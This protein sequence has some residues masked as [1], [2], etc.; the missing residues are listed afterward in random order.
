MGCGSSNT[1]NPLQKIKPR[2]IHCLIK[3]RFLRQNTPHPKL[4]TTP[5]IRQESFPSSKDPGPAQSSSQKIAR[6]KLSQYIKNSHSLNGSRSKSNGGMLRE[7]P[8][9]PINGADEY[10]ANFQ[11]IGKK[12]FSKSGTMSVHPRIFGMNTDSIHHQRRNCNQMSNPTPISG[13]HLEKILQGDESTSLL[14]EED[15]DLHDTCEL[16]S[17]QVASSRNC[18][19]IASIEKLSDMNDSYDYNGSNGKTPVDSSCENICKIS[20]HPYPSS[21]KKMSIVE[22]KKFDEYFQTRQKKDSNLI[23]DQAENTGLLSKSKSR[24]SFKVSK[25]SSA[26]QGKYRSPSEKRNPE[27]SISKAKFVHEPM[28]IDEN[29]ESYKSPRKKIEVMP[30]GIDGSEYQFQNFCQ[31]K[32]INLTRRRSSHQNPDPQSGWVLPRKRLLN[33][34]IDKSCSKLEESLIFRESPSHASYEWIPESTFRA[35]PDPN[36][37]KNR[38]KNIFRNRMVPHFVE[39]S[40]SE[41]EFHRIPKTEEFSTIN[42]ARVVLTKKPPKLQKS[43]MLV[44]SQLNAFMRKRNLSFKIKKPKEESPTRSSGQGDPETPGTVTYSMGSFPG[45]ATGYGDK[46][47][48]QIKRM[49]DKLKVAEVMKLDQRIAL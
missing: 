7:L 3:D 10:F 35:T 46:E 38:P 9:S 5:P 2:D 24:A 19:R 28:K 39:K 32:I 27:F 18:H 15:Q 26:S 49:K 41:N 22:S 31:K 29:L 40:C 4:I 20:R 48:K 30:P 17:S 42:D 1:S 45:K 14:V 33:K 8:R 36:L 34:D 12:C 21:P 16:L 44:A 25:T 23:I 11:K 6:I 13:I 37:V 43:K 47:S